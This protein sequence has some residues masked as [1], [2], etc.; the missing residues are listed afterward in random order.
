MFWSGGD[1]PQAAWEAEQRTG[2]VERDAPRPATILKVA[3]ELEAQGAEIRE[4]FKK[5]S[6]PL[7]EVVLPIHLVR[8]DRE[9]FVE[10]ETGPWDNGKAETVIRK[11]AAVRTSDHAQ[12]ELEIASAYPVPREV[13]FLFA[14]SPAALLQL[15]LFDLDLDDPERSAEDFRR[16]ATAHWG[17][18][19]D[20]DAGFLPLAEELLLAALDFEESPPIL[21]GL[22]SGLG[23]FVGEVIRRNAG[24]VGTWG[25]TRNSSQGPVLEF[26]HLALDPVRKSR[27]FL[28][29][30]Q[31]ESIAFYT[32]HALKRLDG[33]RI[34]QP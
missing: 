11:A 5:V 13:A 25:R 7:G 17:V 6:S 21:D 28:L 24:Q 30:G 29:E 4:L 20:Y 15:A 22:V 31:A 33:G 2:T 19:L 14:R 32:N 34:E 10:V 16:V 26:E 8:G 12:A 9:T 27:A 3:S 18:E 1:T 23:L